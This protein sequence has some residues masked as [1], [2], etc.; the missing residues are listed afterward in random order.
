MALEVLVGC[1]NSLLPPA[2]TGTQVLSGEAQQ[3]DDRSKTRGGGGSASLTRVSTFTSRFIAEMEAPDSLSKGDSSNSQ[4]RHSTT[5]TY[6][7]MSDDLQGLLI[8]GRN[9][10][11]RFESMSA[12]ELKVGLLSCYN[13]N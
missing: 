10:V 1:V 3:N 6:S 5:S 2:L 13:P 12:A 7:G 9:V 8:P 4:S 11:L